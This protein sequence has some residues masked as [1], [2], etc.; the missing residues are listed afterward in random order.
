MVPRECLPLYIRA[1][2][3]DGASFIKAAVKDLQSHRI[4]FPNLAKA[5]SYRGF[6]FCKFSCSPSR[7]GRLVCYHPRGW[8]VSVCE[9]SLCTLLQCLLVPGTYVTLILS[10][11]NRLR[12]C[13]SLGGRLGKHFPVWSAGVYFLCI[14]FNKQL[15]IAFNEPVHKLTHASSVDI[16][17]MD[18]SINWREKN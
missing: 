6:A 3:N 11:K 12:C 5:K 13:L 14:P 8:R 7:Q 1:R 2:T 9:V 4:C 16:D 10:H 17:N 15:P 18:L